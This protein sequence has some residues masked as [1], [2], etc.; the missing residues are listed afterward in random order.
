MSSGHL[1]EKYRQLWDASDAPPDLS[2]FL[3]DI[4]E[5]N[6]RDCLDIM[7]VDQHRRW[8]CGKPSPIENYVKTLATKDPDDELVVELI[9]E[10][11]GYREER[12]GE[13]DLPAFLASIPEL[14]SQVRDRLGALDRASGSTHSHSTSRSQPTVVASI[15]ARS[16]IGRYDIIRQLGKGTFG[17]V[18]LAKDSE[19]QREVAIK[20]PSQ[21]RLELAGGVDSFLQEARVV[22]A[23]DHNGIVPVYDVGKLDTGECYVVSK[24][25]VGGDLRR[26][27]RDEKPTH[28]RSASMVA[29]I[30]RALHQAHRKGLVHRDIK[31][32]NILVD[33]QGDPHIIDF[34]LALRDEE[35]H[36]GTTLVGT[37]AYM[38]PEQARGEGHRVDPR[39]DIYSLGV[40]LYELLTGG[41]PHRSS[42]TS[43]LLDLVK[44]VE[45]RPPRQINDS[46]SRELDRICLKA[47]AHRRS[48]RYST[49]LDLAE[50]LE[51][52]IEEA[53]DRISSS[54]SRPPDSAQQDSSLENAK[55]DSSLSKDSGSGSSGQ[56]KVLVVP[57]GLRSFD[58]ADADFFLELIPGPRDRHGL[59]DTIRFWKRKLE[60]TNAEATFP[61]GLLYGP[62]GCGKSSFVKAGLIPRLGGHVTVLYVEATGEDTESTV[63]DNLR[64]HFPQL[65]TCETLT[66]AL[67]KLRRVVLSDGH[68]V[69]LIIDQFEQWLHIW[70]GKSCSLSQ[71]MMQCDGG[72]VQ[73]IVG[74]RDDFWMAATRFMRELEVRLVEGE[75]SAAVDVFGIR[76]SENVLAAFGRAYGALPSKPSDATSQN[77][78]FVRQAVAGLAEDGKVIPVRLA[79]FS[80]MLKNREWK[81]ST[82]Y[83]LGGT[84]GI[85]VAFL[86]DAFGAHA[87]PSNRMHADAA[88]AVLDV[89]LPGQSSNIRGKIQSRERLLEASGYTSE[90]EFQELLHVLDVELRLI[91][92]ADASG[93]TDSVLADSPESAQFYQLTHD[94]LVPSVRDWMNRRRQTTMSGRAELRLETR[95]DIWSQRPEFRSL[96]S[97]AEFVTIATLTSRKTWTDEQR[98]MM[99]SASRSYGLLLAL[100]LVIL[101]AMGWA[102]RSFYGNLRATSF[103]DQLLVAKVQDVPELIQ[104][105]ELYAAWSQPLLREVLQSN[106]IGRRARRNVAMALLPNDETQL[107]LLKNEIITAEPVELPVLVQAVAGSRDRVIEYLRPELTSQ[108]QRTRLNAAT[109]LAALGATDRKLWEGI[110]ETIAY[111]LTESPLGLSSYLPQ[112]KPVAEVLIPTL[113]K[114]VA[115]DQV[116]QRDAAAVVLNE[117]YNPTPIELADLIEQTTAEQFRILFPL[118]EKHGQRLI[119]ILTERFREKRHTP[120]QESDVKDKSVPDAIRTEFRNENGIIHDSFALVPWLSLDRVETLVTDLKQYG[121]RP[122]RL[123]PFSTT[124]GLRAAVLWSRD[125]RE[126]EFAIGLTADE[127]TERAKSLESKD[128]LACDVAGYLDANKQE[129]FAA[130]WESRD[131]SGEQREFYFG[132]SNEESLRQQQEFANRGFRAFTRHLYTFEDLTTLRHSMIWGSDAQHVDEFYVD[133][134][135]NEEFAVTSRAYDCP[136]DVCVMRHKKTDAYYGAVWVMVDRDYDRDIRF[137]LTPVEHLQSVQELIDDGY[138]PSSLTSA[139]VADGIQQVASIWRRP[140]T[141]PESK[142]RFAR[143]QANLAAALT[144]LN[145]M[146]E[147][148]SRLERDDNVALRTELTHVFHSHGCNP[149]QVIEAMNSSQHLTTQRAL[150]LSLGEFP[151]NTISNKH[152]DA[153]LTKVRDLY[154]RSPDSGM[155]SAAEWCL[156]K[157]RQKPHT[158][159][160]LPSEDRDWF[161]NGTG[162]T[163]ITVDLS[164]QQTP[165]VMGCYRGEIGSKWRERTHSVW[166]KRRFAIS[167]CEVT[168]E[169]FTR[170]VNEIPDAAFVV[171]KDDPANAAQSRVNWYQAARFCNWLSGVEGIPKE[172]WC[173]AVSEDGKLQLA[174]NYLSKR[175]YRLPTEA[176]WEYCCRAGTRT[177]RAFGDSDERLGSFGWFSENSGQ[178]VK[179]VGLLKPNALGLFDTLGNVGEW[180]QEKWIGKLSRNNKVVNDDHEDGL[181]AEREEMRVTKGG[182]FSDVSAELRSADRTGIFPYVGLDTTGFRVVQTLPK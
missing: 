169:H 161:V 18:Y 4:G 133:T 147:V 74:V 51:A 135:F 72:R 148:V 15:A 76:H 153:L 95:V 112:L 114:L 21:Q 24:Y 116:Y 57:K 8:K 45:V 33:T 125:N 40:V 158:K 115:S 150:L 59:P 42:T 174:E 131:A 155:H 5:L 181:S 159:P 6:A 48:D 22:A 157:W 55:T 165:F 60:E 69:V 99:R 145:R 53:S 13:V 142:F 36:R 164:N 88:K 138:R 46:I 132:Q 139:E 16:R 94:F 144:R 80:Q 78:Q 87:P 105:N 178:H 27:M 38:S 56:A 20:V 100:G 29:S 66:K 47:L 81:T 127:M 25:I 70:D 93:A 2:Q 101:I 10:E 179:Q 120:W 58:G 86:E 118:I 19:L 98:R 177:T 107:E 124:E 11:I 160:C 163:M 122:I 31:P 168:V 65:D 73:A 113:R 140:K 129:R 91:T 173:Y 26:Y 172:E 126:W 41:R 61:V 109:T 32:G 170:F 90:Q 39:S 166:I 50:E 151:I 68:K 108:N 1:V 44:N 89:L 128:L 37:P 52:Y 111:D 104:E 97:L 162:Q 9:D 3:E 62:S 119:P 12:D 23:L 130:L 17:V 121:Y 54:Q 63:L 103:R 84:A 180:C 141:T 136:I 123:R 28:L 110:G 117:Y 35:F 82:L 83:Q 167:A 7:L 14:A 146:D 75:N 134:F 79:L 85:G 71:A 30:S 34:G 43:E 175:G 77:K 143:Q 49:A 67:G 152:R 171:R 137:G 176:E 106:S 102:G 154:D 96:P 64:R 92:P 156:R 182:S 149:D